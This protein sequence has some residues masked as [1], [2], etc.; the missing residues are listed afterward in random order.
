RWGASARERIRLRVER[1]SGAGAPGAC[2]PDARQHGARGDEPRECLETCGPGWVSTR[3]RRRGHRVGAA[4]AARAAGG[5]RVGSEVL[6]R[7]TPRRQAVAGLG[8][9]AGGP[10]AGRAR[11]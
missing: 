9:R 11:A 7:V 1:D 4:A 10:G 8:T 3:L 5:A 6:E 2:A